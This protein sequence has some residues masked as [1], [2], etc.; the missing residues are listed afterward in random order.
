MRSKN[1]RRRSKTGNKVRSDKER[2]D[3]LFERRKTRVAEDEEEKR[4][5]GGG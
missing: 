4:N 1:R 2:D 3:K 5:R